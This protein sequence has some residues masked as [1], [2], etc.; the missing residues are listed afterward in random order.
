[1]Q[2]LTRKYLEA[3]AIDHHCRGLS[4]SEFWDQ[5]RH[6]VALA[7]P[8]DRGRFHALVRRLTS[9]VAAGDL[10][11]AMPVGD[12]WPRPCPWELDEQEATV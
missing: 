6:E 11:G 4:W 5:Y 3:A 10:D 1:M 7:E 8:W 12:G 2:N 9:L